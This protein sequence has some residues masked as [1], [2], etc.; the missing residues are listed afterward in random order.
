MVEHQKMKEKAKHHM[1][2]LATTYISRINFMNPFTG[3]AQVF[4]GFFEIKLTTVCQLHNLKDFH[5]YSAQGNPRDLTAKAF[6]NLH[7]SHSEHKADSFRMTTDTEIS[8]S[9][10]WSC[11]S[12]SIFSFSHFLPRSLILNHFYSCRKHRKIICSKP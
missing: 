11:C 8:T 1:L 9:Q 10:E 12:P 2:A 6:S 5:S 7:H 3:R 4:V